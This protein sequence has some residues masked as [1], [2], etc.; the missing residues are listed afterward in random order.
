[1]HAGRYLLLGGLA[2]SLLATGFVAGYLYR[3][4]PTPSRP[5]GV[6]APGGE[7]QDIVGPLDP[8]GTEVSV[9]SRAS[10][11]GV[12]GRLE[13]TARRH[14][15]QVAELSRRENSLH[16]EIRVGGGVFPVTLWWPLP[17]V[18]APPRLAIVIDDLGQSREEA[19]AFLDL[20]M[21]V[22]PAVLP[23]LPH[24]GAVAR[25]ARERGREVLLH[26]P[27]EPQGY[28]A[29]DPGEGALLERMEEAEIRRLLAGNLA[30]VPGVAGVNN[31]MGSRLTELEEPMSWVMD[32]LGSRGLYFLD[33][34]TSP[35]SVAARVAD[36]LGV[37]ATRRDVFLD[38]ERDEEKIGVQIQKAIDAARASGFAV[39][40]G[41]PHSA[42]RRA[43]L[44]W[45]PIIEASGVKVVPL[46][47]GLRRGDGV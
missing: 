43:L 45:A 46:G 14:G 26:L 22:T 34:L 28:P 9:D 36:R 6:S 41:H 39:A 11:L 16:L 47:E 19:V 4:T 5:P 27:M 33:S 3:G 31:H 42:T 15:A 2:V 29:R 24:S 23:H 38:N 13:E 25:L 40:I 10:A 37:R 32:E 30:A 20:P 7:F 1:M 35:R 17:A 18:S 8:R 44:R 21:A 12:R